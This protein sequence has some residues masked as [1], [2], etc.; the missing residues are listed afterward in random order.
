M[1]KD[2]FKAI[3]MNIVNQILDLAETDVSKRQAINDQCDDF[4][5]QLLAQT[6]LEARI[7]ELDSLPIEFAVTR[8]GKEYGFVHEDRINYR[9]A[10][11]KSPQKGTVE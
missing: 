8:Q 10:E 11:L 6:A 5:I 2:E 9:L 4:V 1:N 7:D 3:A